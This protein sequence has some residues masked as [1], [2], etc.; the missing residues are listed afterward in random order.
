MHVLKGGKMLWGG[1]LQLLHVPTGELP[2]PQLPWHNITVAGK[3]WR[4]KMNPAELAQDH[5]QEV[6]NV[7]AVFCPLLQLPHHCG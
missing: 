1:K 3:S 2:A 7:F 4:N 6:G 5:A